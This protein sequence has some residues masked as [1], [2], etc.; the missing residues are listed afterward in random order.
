MHCVFV[1]SRA[2]RSARALGRE[3]REI[4]LLP[5]LCAAHKELEALF[6]RAA[7]RMQ[8]SLQRPRD[9]EKCEE[10]FPGNEDKLFTAYNIIDCEK[11]REDAKE[12]LDEEYKEFYDTHRVIAFSSR[13]VDQKCQWDM[14]KSFE[15]LKKISPMRG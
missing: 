5:R 8:Y 13:F 6:I 1:H 3:V 15:L 2:E 11:A 4:Y 10:M 7:A 14:L 12:E 9:A